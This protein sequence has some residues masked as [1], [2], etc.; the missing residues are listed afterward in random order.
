MSI[1]IGNIFISALFSV[2][3]VSVSAVSKSCRYC[4]YYG[5]GNKL[6]IGNFYKWYRRYWLENTTHVL[7]QFELDLQISTFLLVELPLA[8]LFARKMAAASWPALAARCR[9]VSPEKYQEMCIVQNKR[10]WSWKHYQ[11]TWT[12]VLKK[13]KKKKRMGVL[14]CK[15]TTLLTGLYEH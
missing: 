3:A 9:I 1:G 5:I 4:R 6:S 7:I 2:P 13:K 11:C 10:P 12:G 14:I 8:P 15:R